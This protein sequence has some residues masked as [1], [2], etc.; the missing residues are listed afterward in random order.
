MENKRN[1]K[2]DEIS[3]EQMEIINCYKREIVTWS[4]EKRQ[5]ER[6]IYEVK[7]EDGKSYNSLFAMVAFLVNPMITIFVKLIP[8]S[9]Y[10]YLAMAVIVLT[11]SLVFLW[12][13]GRQRLYKNI[14]VLKLL[15]EIDENECGEATKELNEEESDVLS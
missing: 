8:E 1:I 4:K 2:M 11:V 12:M 9:G 10:I 14:A 15:E 3:S 5:A 7:V 6:V 13:N